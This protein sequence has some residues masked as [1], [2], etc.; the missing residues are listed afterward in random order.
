MVPTYAIALVDTSLGVKVLA[1][2]AMY[3]GVVVM[4]V[5]WLTFAIRYTGRGPTLSRRRIGVLLVVPAITVI[6]V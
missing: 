3:L 1:S 4:P 5:A 2:K 6:L